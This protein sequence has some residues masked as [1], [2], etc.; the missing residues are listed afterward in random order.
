M[1]HF[2]FSLEMTKNE[3]KY[4]KKIL[5]INRSVFYSTL[6]IFIFDC[7]VW[8]KDGISILCAI[9]MGIILINCLHSLA[10]IF[11]IK[12]DIKWNIRKKKRLE[13]YKDDEDFKNAVRYHEEAKQTYDA[14][15]KKLNELFIENKLQESAQSNLNV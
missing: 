6:A 13:K 3:L 15:F 5:L 9:C 8:Y 1:D 14:Q 2:D 11:Q 12:T 10:Q 4:D 7:Y